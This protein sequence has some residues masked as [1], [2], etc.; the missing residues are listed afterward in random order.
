[1]TIPFFKMLRKWLKKAK[2]FLKAA[3]NMGIN[4]HIVYFCAEN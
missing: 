4:T 1:M 2:V 3:L